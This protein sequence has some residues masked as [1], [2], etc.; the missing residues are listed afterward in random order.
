MN[1]QPIKFIQRLCIK[2]PITIQL[3]NTHNR[4]DSHADY[5]MLWTSIVAIHTANHRPY[6]RRTSIQPTTLMYVC[7]CWLL[8]FMLNELENSHKWPQIARL[9]IVLK[10]KFLTH[11]GPCSISPS[12][13]SLARSSEIYRDISLNVRIWVLR[14]L[15]YR[16]W[17]RA[18]AVKL[19]TYAYRR[20]QKALDSE[21]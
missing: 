3:M 8:A 20:N 19:N 11:R 4:Y 17:H 12:Q 14:P 5:E 18:R 7:L 10:D 15:S 2:Q 16:R 6:N 1:K 13:N 9:R 21:T